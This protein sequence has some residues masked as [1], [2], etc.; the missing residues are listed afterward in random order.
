MSFNRRLMLCFAIT[1]C[2]W[3]LQVFGAADVSAREPFFMPAP[4]MEAYDFPKAAEEIKLRGLLLTADVSRAVVYDKSSRS[5]RVLKPRDRLEVTLEGLRHEFRVEG[6]G[7][8][9]LLL[10]GMDGYLYETG[11]EQ[12]E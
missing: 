3:L 9:R 7:G 10:R 8:R 2:F 5:F 1:G 12:S 6:M 11:V 4:P